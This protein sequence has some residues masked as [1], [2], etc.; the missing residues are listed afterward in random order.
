MLFQRTQT[1]RH[2]AQAHYVNS[3]RELT[4]AEL[5][6]VVGGRRTDFSAFTH[7]LQYNVLFLQPDVSIEN[8]APQAHMRHMPDRDLNRNHRVH[9]LD[10]P[11]YG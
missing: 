1:Q 7:H 5:T 9:R 11:M 6:S 10:A 8:N 3:E 4:D 2:L